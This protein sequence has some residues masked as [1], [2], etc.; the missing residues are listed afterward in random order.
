[1]SELERLRLSPMR[2]SGRVMEL[3]LDRALQ[4][5]GLR[6]DAVRR[7]PCPDRAHIRYS[8][9]R[10]SNAERVGLVELRPRWGDHHFGLG[11]LGVLSGR[12]R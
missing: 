7:R 9:R 12:V 11:G 10:G 3:A 2:V 5:R 4:V 6:A 8:E 1:M